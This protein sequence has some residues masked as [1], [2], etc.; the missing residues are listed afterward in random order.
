M[1]GMGRA[2]KPKNDVDVTASRRGH[3]L[4]A[5]VSDAFW[6]LLKQVAKK[7]RRKVAPTVVIL[8]EEALRARGHDV[9]PPEDHA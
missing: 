2:R 1:V 9:P 5:R 6:D 3:Q 4:P 7:E 8:L